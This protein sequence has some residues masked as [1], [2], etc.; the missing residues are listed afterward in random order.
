MRIKI[1]QISLIKDANKIGFAQYIF[2]DIGEKIVPFPVPKKFALSGVL[3]N[4]EVP[5]FFDIQIN[6][7]DCEVEFPTEEPWKQT[8]VNVYD[9][10]NFYFKDYKIT[11]VGA[12]F[13]FGDNIKIE[14]LE[15]EQWRE[16]N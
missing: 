9:E 6:I 12:Q 15:V 8:I 11:Y 5:K 4:C 1:V 7:R 13:V 10:R 14:N 16:D 3:L 2:G